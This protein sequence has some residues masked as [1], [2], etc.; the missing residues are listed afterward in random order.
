MKTGI[1]K[2]LDLN[3][4]R[5]QGGRTFLLPCVRYSAVV[6]CVEQS[7][8]NAFE[9]AVLG[10]AS[11][12]C[13]ETQDIASML[14]IDASLVN[15]VQNMLI[16]RHLL[17]AETLSP[18]ASGQA[19][20]SG[21]SGGEPQPCVVSLFVEQWSGSL[22]PAVIQ[23]ALRVCTVAQGKTQEEGLET[24]SIL[25]AK[26]ELERAVVI[27]PQISEE[28]VSVPAPVGIK[29]ALD[30]QR[31][32]ARRGFLPS[33][34]SFLRLKAY[35]MPQISSSQETANLFYL[36]VRLY[37]S[38]DGESVVCDDPFGRGR[39]ETLGKLLVQHPQYQTCLKI[40]LRS[41]KEQGLSD[42]KIQLKG[43]DIGFHRLYP[44]LAHA[45]SVANNAR[46]K[47]QE[48]IL[49]AYSALEWAF[50]GLLT[51]EQRKSSAALLD[52]SERER[53]RL[54]SQDCDTLHLKWPQENLF[55]LTML[56]IRKLR[57][58]MV[59]DTAPGLEF[60]LACN[61]VTA[62]RDQSHS[63]RRLPPELGGDFLLNLHRLR[64]LRNQVAHAAVAVDNIQNEAQWYADW[65]RRI[66]DALYAPY[67]DESTGGATYH[68]SPE[69]LRI[70]ARLELMEDM[71]D[72]YR[73]LSDWQPKLMDMFVEACAKAVEKDY[74]RAI[75]SL[76][77][78]VQHLLHMCLCRWLQKREASKVPLEYTQIAKKCCQ[79]GML[80]EE[81][82][83][84]ALDTVRQ[85]FYLKSLGSGKSTTLGANVL[86]LLTLI[87][88]D[89]LAEIAKKKIDTLVQDIAL[90]CTLRG[91]GN[92][93]AR[94]SNDW[95]S[96]RKIFL[97]PDY[98]LLL[99]KL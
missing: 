25:R 65:M 61:I 20:V 44:E 21:E 74:S 45:M 2:V 73:Y 56:D 85:G 27:P 4:P 71:G 99:L 46:E 53:E 51:G 66:I 59:R 77:G 98:L 39:S 78:G 8:C 43:Y 81:K 13:T 38:K 87:P 5:P 35:D 89:V 57:N 79:A 80:K 11:L 17:D 47:A 14:C 96:V 40:L 28:E 52:S 32:D 67:R 15:F 24:I 6:Q 33:G 12:G 58:C 86:A 97:N 48:R 76:A 88:T 10:L 30:H 36:P 34:I 90:L 54:L 42:S 9:E 16:Q 60:S 82:L 18:T 93:M 69:K 92:G 72:L 19:V 37:L 84:E 68:I 64:V 62:A 75:T 94:S 83:P 23:G 3:Y 49:A 29:N 31:E 41:A 26:S 63:L 22:L 50:S 7:A 95:E 55:W 1:P 91:H 70:A